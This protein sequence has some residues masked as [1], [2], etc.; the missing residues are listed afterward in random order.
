MNERIY[1]ILYSIRP[2]SDFRRSEDFIEDEL[3]DSFD[4]IEL[5][6]RLE[7]CF[8]IKIDGVDIIPENFSNVDIICKMIQKGQ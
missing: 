1:E 8:G 3:I 5:V 7:E 2:E 4:V 6:S